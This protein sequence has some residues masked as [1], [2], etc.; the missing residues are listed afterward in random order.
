L[1]EKSLHVR[2]DKKTFPAG[3]P[4]YLKSGSPNIDV[5]RAL[6][7][8]G[9]V[10]IPNGLS[11]ASPAV[12]WAW[13]RY[14]AAISPQPSLL[15]TKPFVDLE[16]HLKSVLSDDFGV[17]MT[18]QWLSDS[19]KGF[20]Q[21]VGG[22]L[23]IL[24]YS[25]FMKS[26]PP[27]GKKVGPRKS[28]DFVVLDGNDKW[29][30][31][32]CKG[33]QTSLANSLQQLKRA[34]QQKSAI[35]LM[36]TFKG[37]SLAAGLYLA[38]E[39][40]GQTSRIVV[41]DPETPDPLIR[42]ESAEI[43]YRAAHRIT[44][45]RCL[46]LA[47]MPL[48]AYE[49]AFAETEDTRLQFLFT[50]YERSRSQLPLSE[51]IGTA[52]EELNATREEFEINGESYS[53]RK[54]AFEIPWPVNDYQPRRVTVRQGIRSTYLDA[55]RSESPG[56]LLESIEDNSKDAISEGTVSFTENDNDAS[57]RQG[58]LFICTLHFD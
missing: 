18:M 3:V 13:I 56:N 8:L 27:S 45:A 35:D 58:E 33:T 22:R 36:G 20:K 7:M 26:V 28:P 25:H 10:T 23:F 30:V 48:L 51:R 6:M 11:V 4:H 34:R 2:V 40:S 17:A 41:H 38:S 55:I 9:N 29:H 43:A 15:L 12:Y 53:G 16:P 52:V 32:E 57:I 21:V 31:I 37:S 14:F 39:G 24:N 1:L 5:R 47:G 46:G 49:A 42:V 50:S 19:V 54:I 44:T